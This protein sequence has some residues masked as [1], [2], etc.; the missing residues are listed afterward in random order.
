MDPFVGL[1][2]SAVACARLD[3]NFIGADIDDTYLRQAVE[4]TRTALLDEAASRKR[5]VKARVEMR[6]ERAGKAG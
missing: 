6:A 1:G 5:P 4:R 2:S 3:V